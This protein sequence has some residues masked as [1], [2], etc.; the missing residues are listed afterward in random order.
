MPTHVDDATGVQ[1]PVSHFLFGLFVRSISSPGLKDEVTSSGTSRDS[2]S[3]YHCRHVNS[4]Q[5]TRQYIVSSTLGRT[6]QG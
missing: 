2:R 1:H 3:R 6:S 5:H 4:I